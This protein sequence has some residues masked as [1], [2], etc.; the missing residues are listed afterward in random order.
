MPSRPSVAPELIRAISHPVRLRIFVALDQR[1][2]TLAELMIAIDADRR[3]TLRHLRQMEAAG[4]V[5]SVNGPAGPVY[6]TVTGPYFSDTD[7]G[8]LPLAIRRAG[9]AACL[10]NVQ[11]S[12]AHALSDGGFDRDDIHVSRTSVAVGAADWQRLAD[13]LAETLERIGTVRDDAAETPSQPGD[14]QAT[15]VLML[16]D[17]GPAGDGA[18]HSPGTFSR[19][20]ALL[21]AWDLNEDLAELLVPAEA[22]DWEAIIEHADQLRVLAS[23]A[24]YAE[25]ARL[26]R[27]T[28]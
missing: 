5:C 26:E 20:E 25:R 11:A 12:A 4:V 24:Q 14:V 22:T 2:M 9:V 15:V 6:E 7:Y 10:A 3:C 18:I 1:P 19:E 21:R 23:A 17:S 8:T 16:Y 13:E 27:Q 28:A